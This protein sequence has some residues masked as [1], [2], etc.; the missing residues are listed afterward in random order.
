MILVISGPGP[1]RA[2][3]KIK[4]MLKSIELPPGF[5]IELYSSA[6]PNARNM[7]LSPSGV[8]FVGTRKAGRVYAVVDQNAD[9]KADKVITVAKGLDTPNGVALWHGDLY[10]AEVSR[11]LRFADIESKLQN[12][13]A[14]EVVYKNLPKNR[15]HGFKF[16]RF[17]PD[18]LLYVPVGAPCNV[19]LKNDPI[20]STIIK[21]PRNGDNF[22]IMANGVR[23]CAGFDWHPRT[24]KLWFTDNG[25]DWLSDDEPLD[26]LNYAPIQGLH[27][28]FP[29]CHGK[30]ISDP[31]FGAQRSCRQF[32]PPV[33]ELGPHAAALGMRF[34][35]GSMFPEHYRNQIFIAEHGSSR[36]RRKKT[37]YRI[38]FVR[39][40]GDNAVS[41]APFAR[42]W[43][44]RDMV[45]GRPVDIENM[46]DGSLL[47]SDDKNGAIYRITYRKD[48]DELDE[49]LD[50]I[51]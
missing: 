50:V 22:K 48:K 43:Q 26:E 15:I 29:F 6:V 39:L 27:F 8:L 33:I 19:C 46:P 20:Y 41:Y 40:D 10:V 2:D 38:S 5:Q 1:V 3:L 23:N 44:I 12:P 49:Y 16:I 42:G 28:G 35:T 7:A 14:P 11:I 25:R 31:Q 47:V 17:G 24:N 18:G 36:N 34:Y 30:N 21:I 13:G 32:N 51:W 4:M 9:F 45:W 37:G